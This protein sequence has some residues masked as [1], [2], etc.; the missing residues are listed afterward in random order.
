MIVGLLFGLYLAHRNS[1]PIHRMI[2]IMKEQ[3]GR[4][5]LTE[6]NE[7]DFLMNWSMTN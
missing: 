1:V 5:E 7:F 3:F 2:S 4:D 6:R